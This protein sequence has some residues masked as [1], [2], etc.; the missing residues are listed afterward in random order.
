M[1]DY[2][3]RFNAYLIG[4]PHDRNSDA[5]MTMARCKQ[6]DCGYCAKR[7]RS[8]WHAVV[9]KYMT[10]GAAS[11]TWVFY[12]IT[13]RGENR[14]YIRSMRTVQ[15]GF[16]KLI[17]RMSRM[18]VGQ[19]GKLSYVR[20]YEKHADGSIHIHMIAN[21][22]PDDLKPLK[23]VKIKDVARKVGKGSRTLCNAAVSC[24][25]GN[26]FQCERVNTDDAGLLTGY[27]TKYMTKGAHQMPKGVRRIQTSRDIKFKTAPSGDYQWAITKTFTFRD[28]TFYRLV[29]NVLITDLNSMKKI[30]Y[31]D[32]DDNDNYKPSYL[33]D[34]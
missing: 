9:L 31:N 33:K 23:I 25:L 8:Q 28:F 32:F 16:A 24:G 7:N 14:G 21:L 26:I 3:K 6:W 30:H 10:A 13:A 34:V 4:V 11:Q 2:C 1:P 22:V 19:G 5:I 20:V 29:V 18:K 12:T 17:K 27:I 15:Q